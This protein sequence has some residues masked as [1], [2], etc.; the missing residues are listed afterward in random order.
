MLS[1]SLTSR[2]LR[3]PWIMKSNG[4]PSP[5]TGHWMRP[6]DT[7]RLA[8]S[9]IK[10]KK[11]AKSKE[12]SITQEHIYCLQVGWQEVSHLCILMLINKIGTSG[13]GETMRNRLSSY[14]PS[15]DSST[16][17]NGMIHLAGEIRTLH[18]SW[19]HHEQCT[20]SLEGSKLTEIGLLGPGL[21][22]YISN[23]YSI[24]LE[25]TGSGARLL[26]SKDS[27]ASH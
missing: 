7:N 5:V 25:T 10:K 15:P 14:T 24:M 26:E 9:E 12:S 6:T 19:G 16:K 4:V 20:C 22:E 18:P 17:R 13:L 21:I 23:G 27:S 2:G 3:L 1:V 8:Q 11:K